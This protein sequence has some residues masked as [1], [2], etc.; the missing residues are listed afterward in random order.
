MTNPIVKSIFKRVLGKPCWNVRVGH[1]SFLTFEFGQPYL[2]IE[3]PIAAVKGSSRKV[4][5]NLA[6]RR[7]FVKGKWHLWLMHCDWVVQRK[8]KRLGG[9][10]TTAGARRAADFLNGQKLIEVSI[11]PGTVETVFGFDLG[12]TLRTY[13][14]DHRLEQWLLFDP[15]GKVLTLRADGQYSYHSVASTKKTWKP[16]KPSRF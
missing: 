4:R 2:R 11:S 1:G 12:A 13:P 10:S 6:R 8:W 7:I 5:E 3:E 15:S 9:S 14:Y 16:L